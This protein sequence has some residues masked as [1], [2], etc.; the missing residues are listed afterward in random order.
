MRAAAAFAARLRESSLLEKTARV[1]ANLY[2]SLALTGHGH[3]TDRAILLGLG[4]ELPD[5]IEPGTIEPKLA[6]IR[7]AK[8]LKLAGAKEIA[9]EEA[10]DMLWH[11]DK[12][13]AAHSNGMRFT[14][15]DAAGAKIAT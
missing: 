9:F 8:K 4:G 13:L 5:A 1:E 6:A 7:G 10:T 3:G 12:T 11:K 15:F 14:A 2:G